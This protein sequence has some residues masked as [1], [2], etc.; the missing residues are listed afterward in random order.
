LLLLRGYGPLGPFSRRRLAAD[1]R[2]TRSTTRS[3]AS[4]VSDDNAARHRLAAMSLRTTPRDSR[5]EGCGGSMW[6]L[7]TPAS[8]RRSVMRASFPRESALPPTPST[9]PALLLQSSS[10]RWKHTFRCLPRWPSAR[11]CR[12]ES[13]HHEIPPTSDVPLSLMGTLGPLPSVESW[14][15]ASFS[16][17]RPT[18]AADLATDD[19]PGEQLPARQELRLRRLSTTLSEKTH[20]PEPLLRHPRKGVPQPRLGTPS[21]VSVDR[22]LSPAVRSAVNS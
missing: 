10:S 1:S 3:P 5:H 4:G 14:S 9:E 19:S 22:L 7:P 21:T 8:V 12:W 13:L 16:R 15:H 2:A 17:A 6:E 18:Y 11:C 20:R